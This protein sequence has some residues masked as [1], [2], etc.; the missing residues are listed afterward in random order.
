MKYFWVI[1][2]ASLLVLNVAAEEK[3]SPNLVKNADFSQMDSVKTGQPQFWTS[4]V[5]VD[6]NGNNPEVKFQV[7]PSGEGEGNAV[8]I[9]APPPG[10]AGKSA[11]LYLQLIKIKPNTNY[12]VSCLR[13]VKSG[14]APIFFDLRDKNK[15]FVS[16]IG[17]KQAENNGRDRF[18]LCENSFR[19][20]PD[21]HYAQM[22]LSIQN[23]GAGEVEF[24]KPM[25]IEL[26]E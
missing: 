7:I 19:T 21:I 25:L 1:M 9:V 13:R 11:A 3:T 18:S 6:K 15:K 5:R 26:P 23:L 4:Q 2:V 10:K 16:I 8:R 12:Y 22:M 14:W 20:G 24:Y 17:L